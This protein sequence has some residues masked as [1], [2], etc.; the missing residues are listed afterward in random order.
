MLFLDYSREDGE[1][2]PNEFGGRE[3]LDA[4]A[5]LKELN[6]E[7][8]KSF[9]DV[10][11]IAEESTAFPGVSKPVFLGG[12]GFGMKWMMGWMH[13]TL[14]YFSKDPIYRKHHQ[15][16]ITFSLAYAFTENFMLPLSHDEVVYGKHSILGRMPGDEWQRFANLRLL[17]GYMFTHPGTKLLFM[18]GEFAQ[19]EE[20]DF[21]ESLDW[22]L[23]EFEPHQNFKNFYKSLNALYKTTPALYEK[24]FS[25]DGFEWISY[26]RS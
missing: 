25:E 14:D 21:Q 24:G 26:R 15:N 17:Y 12:L 19:Y 23:L 7:V 20:W 4:I 6:E 16:D 8:Y 1:W 11:T 9:P 18:G 10:Q 13:D 2:E 5:F 22:N 3:N